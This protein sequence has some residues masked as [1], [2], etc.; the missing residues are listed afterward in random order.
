MQFRKKSSSASVGVGNG[1]HI[2]IPVKNASERLL[3]LIYK[4]AWLKFN[5]HLID[6]SGRIHSRSIIDEAVKGP[7][8]LVFESDVS[9]TT[10]TTVARECSYTPGGIIDNELACQILESKVIMYDKNWGKYKAATAARPSIIAIIRAAEQEQAEAL[11]KLS[12]ISVDKAKIIVKSRLNSKLLSS[13]FL[14]KDDRSQIQ[15]Y[16]ILVNKDAYHEMGGFRD[17][18]DPEYGTGKAKLFCGDTCVTLHSF[19]HGSHN[20]KLQ[21][22][23]PGLERWIAEASDA[24]LKENFAE[25]LSMSELSN[26]DAAL[27]TKIIAKRLNT[28]TSA[29]TSD[30]KAATKALP[31]PDATSIDPA[32]THSEISDDLLRVF[33]DY[34]VYGRN[35]YTFGG[36]IWNR[37]AFDDLTKRFGV[38]YGHCKYCQ[39]AGDYSSLT[40]LTLSTAPNRVTTWKSAYGIPCASGFWLMDKEGIE[41]V[42]YTS[43]LGARF[44]L[45]I[46]PNF[47]QP[48]PLWEKV[49]K[50]ITNPRCFQQ[51]FGLALCGYLTPELQ[52]A[53]LLKGPGGTGKG[54]M[55][56]VMEAMLPSDRVTGVDLEGMNNPTKAIRLSD[57]VVNFITEVKRNK[58]ISTSSFLKIVAGEMTEGKVL[59]SNEVDFKSHASHI[60]SCNDW[61][62][63]DSYGS[64]IERRL[65]H[66]IIE[67]NK[68]HTEAIT[69]LDKQIVRHELEGV[70]AWAING[71]S[72][73]IQNGLDDAHSLK[74]FKSWSNSLDSVS[75]FILECCMQ[76][77]KRTACVSKTT[78]Y[79]AYK[80][81]CQNSNYTP[82]KKGDF[83]MRV[84]SRGVSTE[85]KNTGDHF[86][87][88]ALK[89]SGK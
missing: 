62:V 15:I 25:F 83:Y 17:P 11:S 59:Y 7:E 64:E 43:D 36:T 68:N 24:E 1:Q 52:S 34:K 42:D 23:M 21:F 20:F 27:L 50:N 65:G 28:K 58:E 55:V 13:D 38:N 89:R 56:K 61:P 60:L 72:D 40:K 6:K 41:R 70:L 87:G 71:V 33:G 73:Y 16:D 22:D 39:R 29:V 46:N 31:T 88:I 76:G 35:V 19:A 78:L 37:T 9:T 49:L 18:L 86:V 3:T 74:L 51:L 69:D 84:E 12:S 48:I 54:T 4:F 57:S 45:G 77:F 66:F 82:L 80:D 32:A 75:L 14:M 44:K 2:F 81:F 10:L 63:L 47:L 30:I 5:S 67:F 8:R 53:G 26:V 79:Q 85:H